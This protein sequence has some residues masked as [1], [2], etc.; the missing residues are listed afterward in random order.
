MAWFLNRRILMKS[1]R[2]VVE[3]GD[4]SAKVGAQGQWL[5]VKDIQGAEGYVAAWYVRKG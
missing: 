1:E 3:S 2:L 4:P 5:K